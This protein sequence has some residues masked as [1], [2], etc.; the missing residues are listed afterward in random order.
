MVSRPPLP[1]AWLVFTFVVPAGADDVATMA[2]LLL[3]SVEALPSFVARSWV[4][5][6]Q[7]RGQA[8]RAT[9][10]PTVGALAIPD[11]MN[12]AMI[13]G[14]RGS[15]VS[16]LSY[17]HARKNVRG[18]EAIYGEKEGWEVQL[19]LKA[20]DVETLMAA[21]RGCEALLGSRTVVA[22]GATS[23]ELQWRKDGVNVTF[24]EAALRTAN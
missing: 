9:G 18:W 21:R 15:F 12:G 1:D 24:D 3:D 6:K 4:I 10:A 13:L 20:V 7:G 22:L 19:N 5:R 17:A 2:Q 23:F 8:V 16:L 11:L 14:P